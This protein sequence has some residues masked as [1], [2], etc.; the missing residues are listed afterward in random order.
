[1]PLNASADDSIEISN[2]AR[3]VSRFPVVAIVSRDVG[4]AYAL[5]LDLAE[6]HSSLVTPSLLGIS[7]ARPLGLHDFSA[8]SGGNAALII[9]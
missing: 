7:Q 1:M 2:S 6:P 4:V 5:Q 3:P 8:L 9:I